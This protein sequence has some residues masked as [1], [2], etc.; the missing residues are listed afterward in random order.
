MKIH[1]PYKLQMGSTK[2]CLNDENFPNCPTSTVLPR[3]PLNFVAD[4]FKNK[5]S[6][7]I[8]YRY[9]LDILILMS[10]LPVCEKIPLL[11]GI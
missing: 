9:I 10:N 5:M 2:T 6:N 11:T 3:T 4:F 8:L 7:N 1:R